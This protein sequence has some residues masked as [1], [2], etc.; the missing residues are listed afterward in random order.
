MRSN[1]P[2]FRIDPKRIGGYGYS[3]GGHLVALAGAGATIKADD[4]QADPAP[5]CHLQAVVAGGAPCD[6]R[7]VPAE[8]RILEYWLGGPRRELP[9]VYKLASP[10]QHVSPACPPMFFFHGEH[11]LL[12]PLITVKGMTA[13]LARAGVA[14]ELFIVPDK[15]HV[16]A[17]FDQEALNRGI[18]FLK[19]HLLP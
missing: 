7:F 6:F 15:G 11:D 9:E 13:Q 5:A 16:M 17:M 10:A 8:Q 1:A 4:V 12:V 18:E 14:S 3:A 19:R 2:Q